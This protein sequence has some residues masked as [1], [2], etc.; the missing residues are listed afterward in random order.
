MHIVIPAPGNSSFDFEKDLTLLEGVT[1][2]D[3]VDINELDI[4]S[5]DFENDTKEFIE[6]TSE[7]PVEKERN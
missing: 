1:I 5:E 4:E 7:E 2:S 3:P 6:E